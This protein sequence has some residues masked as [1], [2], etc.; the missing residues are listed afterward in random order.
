MRR[1]KKENFPIQLWDLRSADAFFFVRL[2]CGKER[3]GFHLLIGEDVFDKRC[4]ASKSSWA[5]TPKASVSFSFPFVFSASDVGVV[6]K[7]F[8]MAQ[9]RG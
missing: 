6:S 7:R 3:T 4:D 2:T 8:L 5:T 9:V 1:S